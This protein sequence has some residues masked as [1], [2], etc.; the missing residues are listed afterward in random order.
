MLKRH[1]GL[2][3]ASFLV[4]AACAT[5][6]A[7]LGAVGET[8]SSSSSS[9]GASPG[10]GG[11]AG[12]DGGFTGAGGAVECPPEAKLIYVAD[13]TGDLFTF[14]PSTLGVAELGH[15]HCPGTPGDAIPL[16]MA[17]DR[18]AKAWI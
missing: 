1:H 6:T 15:F 12:A 9:T 2:L 4:P 18:T 5:G 3:C 17:I 11:A 8:A 13:Y 14:D 7:N 16:S 10:S